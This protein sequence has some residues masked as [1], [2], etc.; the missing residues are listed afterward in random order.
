MK[1]KVFA[2]NAGSVLADEICEFLG[3]PRAKAKVGRFKD[4]E[5][6]VQILE[7]VRG[8]DVFI[9]NPIPPPAENLLETIL[10]SRAAR[11]SSADRITL[12]I[13]YLGYNRSDRKSKPREPISARILAD[14]LSITY[15]NRI[16]LFDL[17]SEATSGFFNP[18]IVVDHLYASIVAKEV[19]SGLLPENTVVAS[20]DTGGSKR[21][22]A[23]A[24]QLGQFSG[25][26]IVVFD[27]G[28]RPEPGE[29]GD[30]EIVISGQVE[31]KNILFVDD[32]IDSA[33]TLQRNAKEAKAKGAERIL[34]F[35][36]HGV[37][38]AGA[39]ARLDDSPIEQV[40]VTNSIHHDPAVFSAARRVKIMRISVAKLFAEAIR[41]LHEDESL[42]S[43][44]L[45]S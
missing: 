19:L 36:P 23:Y 35:A 28:E 33:K 24:K 44:I 13:P 30:D 21:A 20:P 40:V 1:L 34:C 45:K 22:R 5:V 8:A 41:L 29:L 27:K 3:R 14:M 4:G 7:D 43:L 42:S 32:I 9:V 38:S 6:E 11:G 31:G 2:G 26:G 18:K 15:P 10:L 39:I 37:F 17:H 12:V 25:Q 16:L